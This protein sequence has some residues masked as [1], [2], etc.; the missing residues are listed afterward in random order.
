MKKLFLCL[1]SIFVATGMSFSATHTITNSGFTFS[2]DSIAISVG[3]TV[4][5]NISSIHTAREVDQATWNADGITSNGGFD[6]P[7]GGGT[8]VLTQ[9]GI[10]YYVC[11]NH[12]SLGMKGIISVNSAMN[13]KSITATIPDHFNLMQNYPNPFNPT[14]V[15]SFDLPAKSFVS[16]KIFDLL[17]KQVSSLVS[18]ELP[19]GR[20]NREWNATDLPSGIYFYR[21][22]A[23][24]F[25][26]TKKLILLR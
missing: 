22:Q 8:I 9:P 18:D 1:S 6:L 14:T 20:Y 15:I 24:S 25:S 11:T 2:P 5:F 7:S 10:H 21:L 23:G 13:I 17:G 4:I 16:L 26:E 12:A 19:A 3:D